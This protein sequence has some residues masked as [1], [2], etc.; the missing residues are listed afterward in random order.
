MIVATCL[1]A[2][3]SSAVTV[4]HT[5][6]FATQM[7]NV[8]KAL[9]APWHGK[10]KKVYE[11]STQRLRR[12]QMITRVIAEESTNEQFTDGW[13]WSADDLGWAVFTMTWFESGRFRYSVHA[14]LWR[15]DAGRSV[16]LGQIM[17]GGNKL[18]GTDETHTRACIRAVERI[19]IMHQRRCLW[20]TAK[21]SQWTMAKV[22]A[23]YGTGYSCSAKVVRVIKQKDGSVKKIYWALRRAGLWQQARSGH[24]LRVYKKK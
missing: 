16:C 7:F 17:N 23:G 10:G 9:P 1:F 2:I 24:L 5:Q 19:M 8:A 18:V 22:F 21:P 13:R 12:V 15:G 3:P 4:T 6:A 14:G 20:K 11:T